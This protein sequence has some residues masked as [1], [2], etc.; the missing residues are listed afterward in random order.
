MLPVKTN[1]YS[2]FAAP[3]LCLLVVLSVFPYVSF[4]QKKAFSELDFHII[5]VENI[6]NKDAFFRYW[7]AGS[8]FGGVVGSPFYIGRA[9]LGIEY[10]HYRVKDGRVPVLDAFFIYSGWSYPFELGGFSVA[11]GLRLGNYRMIF[12]DKTSP[13]RSESDES[14]FSTGVTLDLK[15]MI[16]DRVGVSAGISH[17]TVHTYNKLYNVYIGGGMVV[18]LKTS[19]RV[20]KALSQ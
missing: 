20:S 2:V 13:F 8:G 9:E 17:T 5:K 16:A 19:E 15:Y 4:G 3:V 18:R 12:D 1:R 11:P 10:H 7:E 14:E 6:S